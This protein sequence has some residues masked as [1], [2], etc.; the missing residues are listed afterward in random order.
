MLTVIY[1]SPG[2]VWTGWTSSGNQQRI[3]GFA[4]LWHPFL[5]WGC[6]KFRASPRL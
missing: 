6:C 5:W 3:Y 2:T 1:L 4:H